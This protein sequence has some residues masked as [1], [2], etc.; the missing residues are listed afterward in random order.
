MFYA[1]RCDRFAKQAGQA[2]GRVLERS[3]EE[4]DR[5]PQPILA[6]EGFEYFTHSANADAPAQPILAKQIR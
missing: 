6:V 4:L 5:D 1:P 3:A 2:R